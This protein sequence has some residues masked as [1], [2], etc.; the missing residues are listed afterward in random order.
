M[1]TLL[2]NPTSLAPISS[3]KL[4]PIDKQRLFSD[5]N[6]F[7]PLSTESD[8]SYTYHPEFYEAFSQNSSSSQ[9]SQLALIV[10]GYMTV[11]DKALLPIFNGASDRYLNQVL[12]AI[13]IILDSKDEG[14]DTKAAKIHIINCASR[15]GCLTPCWS[16]SQTVFFNNLICL[17]GSNLRGVSLNNINLSGAELSVVD[18]SGADLNGTDL[19]LANLRCANL[20]GAN[21]SGANLKKAIFWSTDLSMAI[22][23][24]VNLSGVDLKGKNL[25]GTNLQKADLRGADLSETDLRGADLRGTDLR[26]ADL[27][28]ADL[29]GADL[30]GADLSE[31]DLQGAD[32]RGANLIKTQLGEINSSL[33]ELTK[34]TSKT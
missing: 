10:L 13:Q 32:L 5:P 14:N 25:S 15:L 20:S 30:S 1:L 34:T 22:L 3:Q 18:F 24:G 23:F 28:G 7:K 27:R 12:S 2:R 11:Y 8:L 17:S 29:R 6:F 9:H 21:L 19:S 16:S 31:T 33:M 4:T 26:G